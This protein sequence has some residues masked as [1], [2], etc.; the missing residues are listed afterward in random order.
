MN[1]SQSDFPAAH[2][3]DTTWFAIDK[4]GHLGVF[5]SGEDG[6]VPNTFSPDDEFEMED[7]FRAISDLQ[8]DFYIDDLIAKAKNPKRRIS[9]YDWRARKYVT[10][11]MVNER[12][13]NCLF[14]F[15]Q[16][17]PSETDIIKLP[18]SKYKLGWAESFDG[19]T[20]EQWIRDDVLKHVWTQGNFSHFRAGIFEFANDRYGGFPYVL[21]GRPE[22][23]IQISQLPDTYQM[24]F[25]QTSFSKADFSEVRAIQPL[26]Y[27]E[28]ALWGS[29]WV[30]MN[31][32]QQEQD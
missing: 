2:S 29:T 13:Y 3:M 27:F 9:A 25:S 15:D 4:H 32:K 6:P 23:P 7:V 31:G 5:N 10:A 22:V 21:E 24:R 17:I 11:K 16:D 26:E 1:Q 19:P 20:I 30:D 18:H 14:W 12:T 28:C 8:I